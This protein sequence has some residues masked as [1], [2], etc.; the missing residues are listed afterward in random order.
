MV[1]RCRVESASKRSVHCFWCSEPADLGDVFGGAARR[2][3]EAA[4]GFEPNVFDMAGGRG[5]DVTGEH[6]NELTLRQMR[7]TGERCNGEIG[8]EVFGQPVEQFAQ[9]RGGYGLSGEGRGELG[10]PSVR[11]RYTTRCRAVVAAAEKP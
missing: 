11:R 6:P 4:S 3:Q 2:F 10:L 8:V 5:A 9:R 7:P 1:E